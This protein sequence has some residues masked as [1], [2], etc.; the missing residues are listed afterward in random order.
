MSGRSVR[1]LPVCRGA[2]AR[3]LQSQYADGV[4]I[5]RLDKGRV[6]EHRRGRRA[7]SHDHRPNRI[8]AAISGIA[9]QRIGRVAALDYIN[10]AAP[11]YRAAR[12]ARRKNV[13]R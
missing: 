13:Q 3:S 4:R 5:R 10:F 6:F 8:G 11:G 1:R 9:E 12:R 2:C 7:W